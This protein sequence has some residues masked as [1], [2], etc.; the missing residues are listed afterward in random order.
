MAD[1]GLHKRVRRALATDTL[2][3]WDADATYHGNDYEK[4][5]Y[6]GN[7]YCLY[8][9]VGAAEGGD[10]RGVCASDSAASVGSVRGAARQQKQ[11]QP[12]K[13]QAQQDQQQLEQQRALL[14]MAGPE[15]VTQLLKTDSASLHRSFA[16]ARSGRG[17]PGLQR[18]V[19]AV[20]A[21]DKSVRAGSA[22][23]SASGAKGVNG[24]GGAHGEIVA[25]PAH[26]TLAPGVIAELQ[27]ISTRNSGKF[28]DGT[29]RVSP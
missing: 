28:I 1:F 2:V 22:Y 5:Y 7:Q 16:A 21:L 14:A 24:G 13:G 3:P 11:Q 26:N 23:N 15:L 4:S 8:L 10:G 27:E 29:Q 12:A 9:G 19:S 6:G 18:K 20:Q 25:A 17:A